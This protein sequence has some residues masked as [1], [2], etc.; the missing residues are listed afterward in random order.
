MGAKE[1]NKYALGNNGGRPSKYK[2]EYAD[3]VYGLAMLGATEKEIA[4]FFKV[5]EE[6]IARWKKRHKEFCGACERGKMGADAHV[7][8]RLYERA[9][10]FEHDSEEIKVVSKGAGMGSEVTRVPIRKIYPPDANAAMW[11]LQNR[12]GQNWRVK[13]EIDIN[14][15]LEN[16][17]DEDLEKV[18]ALIL[19]KSQLN[20]NKS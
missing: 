9:I 19:E 20:K 14:K 12:R 3:Q 8:V 7:A 4:A 15:H 6:T 5:D 10:G 13:Q 2:E 1:G 16:L 18:V 11:W 17:T